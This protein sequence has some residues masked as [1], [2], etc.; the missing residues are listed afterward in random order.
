MLYP[1]DI[2]EF[3]HNDKT[4]SSEFGAIVLGHSLHITQNTHSPNDPA[5]I[6]W[7]FEEGYRKSAAV[8]RYLFFLSLMSFL[9][10]E[11]HRLYEQVNPESK[12]ETDRSAIATSPAEMLYI[13]RYLYYLDSYG[14]QGD[15]LECGCFRGFSSCCL[16]WACHF[17]GKRLIVADSFQ[18][19]PDVEHPLYRRGH[20][21]GAF[22]AVRGNIATLGRIDSADFIQ[23]WFHESLAG[24][25]HPLCL[26]WVDVDL[27]QSVLD[28]LNHAYPKLCAGGVIFSHEIKRED[29][30][31]YKIQMDVYEKS[32]AK[33]FHNFFHARHINYL[34][35]F[36]TGWLALIVP[37]TED[38]KEDMK[39]LLSPTQ[40]DMLT[41]RNF[42]RGESPLTLFKQ[43]KSD[44]LLRFRG[45]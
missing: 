7:M 3:V 29:I 2:V 20:F 11:I 34:A 27:Y 13:A 1:K 8:K 4:L 15:V 19:L 21:K 45:R 22:E 16:S 33:A 30:K 37:D 42:L 38:M 12:D 10:H 39:V 28:V 26:I 24:F 5:F 41:Q 23:G 17:L 31:G 40:H 35:Q 25:D 6:R 9:F 32:V 44:L 36:L 14:I 18:G 43:L